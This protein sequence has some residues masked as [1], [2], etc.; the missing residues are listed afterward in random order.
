MFTPPLDIVF[1]AIIAG[2]VAFKL[3]KVLGRTSENDRPA[4]LGKYIKDQINQKRSS[5]NVIELPS[6]QSVKTEEK[7]YHEDPD[8]SA[9]L[10]AIHFID[11]N[12]N[13]KKFISGAKKA[14]DLILDAFARGDKTTLSTLLSKDVYPEFADAIDQRIAAGEQ[15]QTTLIAVISSDII[16]ADLMK[17]MA[18]I[19]LKFVS[20]QVNILQSSEGDIISGDPATIERI[21]D[22]WTFSRN[23]ESQN[24]NWQL[25]ATSHHG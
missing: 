20:D 13:T 8:I 19:T 23:V 18:H 5:D 22:Q 9:T 1:F 10:G 16:G 7:P 11:R 2:F 4:D 25:A 3:Y 6:K 21:E 15:L 12:F 24:P 17:N 14:F